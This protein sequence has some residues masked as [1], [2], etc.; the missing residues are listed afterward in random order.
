V[1]DGADPWPVLSYA[2]GQEAFP[3]DATADQWFDH[4]QFTNYRLLG[5]RVALRLI[6]VTKEVPDW[7]WPT[8]SGVVQ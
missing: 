5:R 8:P 3:N 1:I 4:E 2:G 7:K 6:E